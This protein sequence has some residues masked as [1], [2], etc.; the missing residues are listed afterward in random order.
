M[1][2][3]MELLNA[4]PPVDRL[5]GFAMGHDVTA[6]RR[7]SAWEF[8]PCLGPDTLAPEQAQCQE[9]NRALLRG[10]G[11]PKGTM[12]RVGLRTSSVRPQEDQAGDPDQD[13][14]HSQPPPTAY[15]FA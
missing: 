15:R 14:G 12:D 6:L 11:A 7:A 8:Q 5:S 3:L 2:V 13:Q 10:R 9:E 1:M 4:V